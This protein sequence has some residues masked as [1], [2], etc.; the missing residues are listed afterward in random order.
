MLELDHLLWEEWRLEEG[1]KR[2]AKLTGITPA[3][4]G[5]H[6]TGTHNSLLSLGHDKY[7]EIIA[8]DPTHPSVVNLPKEMP[9]EFRPGLFT[10]AVRAYDLTLVEKL[11]ERA[12][13]S[14]ASRHH[15]SRQSPNGEMLT[16]ESI[17]VGGHNFGNFMPFFT[18]CGDMTHPS[19]TSPQGCQLLEFSV[20]HPD[21]QELSRLYKA[22]Q[23]NVPVFH[24]EPAQLLAVLST[25]K[26]KI[27]LNSQ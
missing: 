27:T 8:P 22:L 10:F 21:S 15:V 20:G 9:P 2:F 24:V 5:T 11:I 23:V 16:W 18:F 1:E 12:G 6:P 4:G 3:F 13:L 26:G 19:E 25:F 17:F 7:L 14:V